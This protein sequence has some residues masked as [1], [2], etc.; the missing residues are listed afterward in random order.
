M[1]KPDPDIAGRAGEASA[2]PDTAADL[3]RLTAMLENLQSSFTE[4]ILHLRGQIKGLEERLD[5][6][7]ANERGARKLGARKAKAA[8][9]DDPAAGGRAGG[10]AGRAKTGV[11]RRVKAERAARAAAW[12]AEGMPPTGEAS[13]APPD[14]PASPS[15]P[16]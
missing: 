10:R 2:D 5:L 6:F 4:D 16:G 3:A 14:G 13:D 11:K 12:T 9:A 1:T 8:V 15:R 7:A